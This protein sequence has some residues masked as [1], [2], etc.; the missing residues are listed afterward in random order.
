MSSGMCF[1]KKR[2][3]E[4]SLDIWRFQLGNFF[5]FCG[6]RCYIFQQMVS[7]TCI[8]AIMVIS[9]GKAWKNNGSGLISN[10]LL[11]DHLFLFSKSVTLDDDLEVCLLNF[12]Y[13]VLWESSV[14][15]STNDVFFHRML[16]AGRDLWGSPI[17]LLCWS[18][19]DQIAREGIWQLYN[20][21]G[22]PVIFHFSEEYFLCWC[23][24]QQKMK[25][26]KTK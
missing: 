18:G 24:T 26:T 12:C 8:I 2:K 15:L 23:F 19:L 11:F 22:Q 14:L 10:W 20:F 3:P 4:A 25:F 17:P 13:Y 5:L 6:W 7:K 9:S 21:S 1:L 16:E